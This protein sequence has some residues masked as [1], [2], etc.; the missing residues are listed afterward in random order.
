SGLTTDPPQITITYTPAKT[1]SIAIAG[2]KSLQGHSVVSVAVLS[3]DDFDATTVDAASVCF[4]D[5]EAPAE[6]DCTERDGKSALLDVN[7]DR[8]AD[9][10]LQFETNE[11]GVDPGDTQACLAGA[12]FDRT[13]IA[14]CASII[15]IP[16][17]LPY[18]FLGLPLVG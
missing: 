17:I 15:G 4:G 9:A 18:S 13:R 12:T 8:R 10:L 7:H 14:G 11:A 1:V 6:R 5:A 16:R 3:T 2:R